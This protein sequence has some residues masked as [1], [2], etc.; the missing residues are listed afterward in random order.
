MNKVILSGFISTK[1]EVI[2]T[3]TS[4]SVV[5]FDLAVKRIIA[6]NGIDIDFVPMVAWDKNADSIGRNAKKGDKIFIHGHV[7]IHFQE[8]ATGKR[9]YVEIVID[10]IDFMS[11]KAVGE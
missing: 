2:K 8:I 5:N 11:R 7:Q 10:E 6:F 9:K 3:P 1:I 4:R